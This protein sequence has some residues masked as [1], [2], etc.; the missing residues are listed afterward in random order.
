[1]ARSKINVSQVMEFQRDHVV[2][3]IFQMFKDIS[4]T[5]SINIIKSTVR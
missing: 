5:V 2:D 3:I 1:M 4:C